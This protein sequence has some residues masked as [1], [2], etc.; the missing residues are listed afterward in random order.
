MSSFPPSIIGL[1]HTKSGTV[2]VV[3][4][5]QCLVKSYCWH[6]I[7]SPDL[8]AAVL[9][10]FIVLNGRMKLMKNV[11][12]LHTNHRWVNIIG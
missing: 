8:V 4:V 3:I 12:N 1:G 9:V 7:R 5:G 6:V 10:L 11:P 2:V